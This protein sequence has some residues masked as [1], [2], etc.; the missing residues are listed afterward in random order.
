MFRGKKLR[1]YDEKAVVVD[2]S[3]FRNSLDFLDKKPF[4]EEKADF[5]GDNCIVRNL[6]GFD[7]VEFLGKKQF[8]HGDGGFFGEEMLRLVAYGKGL[9]GGM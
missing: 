2:D 1:F 6:L 3:C 5:V 7:F 9:E 4:C 8:W